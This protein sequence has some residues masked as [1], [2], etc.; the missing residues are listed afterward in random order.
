M[1]KYD[2]GEVMISTTPFSKD[3]MHNIGIRFH[4]ARVLTG[5]KRD[6]FA[7]KHNLS[8]LSIKN[9]EAGLAL[10]RH[11]GLVAAITALKESGVFASSEWLL[12]GS[13]NGPNYYHARNYENDRSKDTVLTEQITLFKHAQ[14]SRGVEPV[15]VA[16]RDGTMVPHYRKGD[17][18]G[19]VVVSPE[20][21]KQ[22]VAH[23]LFHK[24]PWLVRFHDGSFMPTFV[25]C[26]ANKWFINNA[27]DPELKEIATP[28][29]ARIKWHYEVDDGNDAS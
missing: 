27:Q 20:V 28:L 23:H 2:S 29:F 4:T 24:R 3:D 12:Y 18:L 11:E 25:F 5:L 13:G 15:V 6:E 16:V 10:P 7:H 19:G 22:S 9:W 21:V 1:L 17:F 8:P 14:R 26:H